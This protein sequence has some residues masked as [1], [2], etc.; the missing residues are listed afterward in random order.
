MVGYLEECCGEPL[1]LADRVVVDELLTGVVLS[2]A[3]WMARV[4]KVRTFMGGR[5]LS[6]GSAVEYIPARY[7]AIPSLFASGA[8]PVDVAYVQASPGLSLGIHVGYVPEV[9]AVARR[10]VVEV[11]EEMP[12]LRGAPVIDH[13]DE[14]V[15]SRRPLLELPS[16]PPTAGDRAIAEHVVRLI[17]SGSTVEVGLGSLT[18]AVLSLLAGHRRDLRL[19]SGMLGDA[20]VDL[21]ESGALADEE[22]VATTLMGTRRL[23]S[24]AAS[25]PRLRMA[26]ATEVHSVAVLSSVAGFVALNSALEVDLTGQAGAEELAGR[27][28]SGVG[29]QADFAAGATLAPGGRSIIAVP[30]SRIVDGLSGPVSTPRLDV[31]FVVTEHGVAELAGRSLEERETALRAVGPR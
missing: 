17:P 27:R 8:L 1:A 2:D 13:A 30:S 3:P 28:V 14:V 11:N 16:R 19:R 24:W 29:G 5:G 31:G 18:D 7:G 23:Y 6:G 9:L 10:C 21:A 4:G 15:H 22:I 25:E 20:A 12:T 26:P